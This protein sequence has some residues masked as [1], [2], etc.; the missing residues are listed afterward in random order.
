MSFP[1]FVIDLVE[2]MRMRHADYFKP[3]YREP[4]SDVSV[5]DYILFRKRDRFDLPVDNSIVYRKKR[6]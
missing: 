5:P 1:H 2:R 3:V 6:I 4:F